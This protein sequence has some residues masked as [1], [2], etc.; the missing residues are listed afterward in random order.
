MAYKPKTTAESI[1][2]KLKKS[3]ITTE[4]IKPKEQTNSVIIWFA[5]V[6]TGKYRKTNPA[7]L[8]TIP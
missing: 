5:S 1:G 8:D 2:L 7:I 4:I 3:P 6:V